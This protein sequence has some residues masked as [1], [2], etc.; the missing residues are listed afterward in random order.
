[1]NITIIIK[2]DFRLQTTT[3]IDTRADLNCIQEGLVTTIYFKKTN[4]CLST[5]R[6]SR[7]QIEYKLLDAV[8]TND[9]VGIKSSFLFVRK[10]T[11]GIILV[12]LFITLL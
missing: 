9:G 7:L 8:V 12:T 1:M 2:N 10:L 6:G 5:A 3:L 11:R 4:E